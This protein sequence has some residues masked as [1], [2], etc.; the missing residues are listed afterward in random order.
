LAYFVENLKVVS[1]LSVGYDHIDLDACLKRGIIVGNT[2][3]VLTD[4]VADISIGLLLGISRRFTEGLNNVRAGTWGNFTT[5]WLC[6]SQFTGKT[7]GIFGMGR[8]GEAIAKRMV[9]FG[10]SRILYTC[11]SEKPKNHVE[12]SLKSIGQHFNLKSVQKASFAELLKESDVIFIACSLSDET[13]YA[14]DYAAFKQMKR[15]SFIVNTSRGGLIKTDDLTRA[16]KEGLLSGAALDVTDPEPLPKDHEL[17]SLMNEGKV[18][19]LP[20]LG[21]ATMET[22]NKM[23]MMSIENLINGLNGKELASRVS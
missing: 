17:V 12:D 23:G 21:S 22:R 14:F 3:G 13:R 10:I 8:I 7:I 4:A 5:T 15:S 9:P 6:G 11:K 1:T 2:P 18:F 19:I 16:L 20:H